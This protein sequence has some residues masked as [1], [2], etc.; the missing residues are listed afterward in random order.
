MTLRSQALRWDCAFHRK[1]AASEH[2]QA[3][4][5]ARES[6]C[7]NQPGEK[8]TSGVCVDSAATGDVNR[9][10]IQCKT[11]TG[12]DVHTVTTKE[13]LGPEEGGRGRRG[14]GARRGPGLRL[15]NEEWLCPRTL[16]P[17][18]TDQNNRLGEVSTCSVLK[19]Q[20]AVRE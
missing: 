4:N 9:N 20:V 14:E 17:H 5:P 8:A 16:V 19:L 18:V 10:K 7:K 11:R 12:Q 2:P 15:G 13:R 3:R 6:S 1:Q